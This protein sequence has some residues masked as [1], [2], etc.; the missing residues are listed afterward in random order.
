MLSEAKREPTPGTAASKG[1]KREHPSSARR[2]TRRPSPTRD[3]LGAAGSPVRKNEPLAPP[4]DA[5]S[6]LNDVPAALPKRDQ[7]RQQR[8]K[9]HWR[10][11]GDGA[12]GVLSVLEDS[13]VQPGTRRR[14]NEMVDLFGAFCRERSLA[15]GTPE[16]TDAAM[17]QFLNHRFLSGYTSS[18]GVYTVV[19]WMALNPSYGRHGPLCLLRSHRALKGWRRLEPP[20]SRIGVTIYVVSAVAAELIS[21]RR[22][23]MAV[24]TLIYHLGYLRPS[25]NMA[26]RRRCLVAPKPGACESW[27]LLLNSSEFKLMSK[28]GTTDDAVLLDLNEVPRDEARRPEREALKFTYFELVKEMS[29][30]AETI[31]T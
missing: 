11:G 28:T 12:N 3:L 10:R 30:A 22:Q 5:S 27:S 2:P 6:D 8:L 21:R 18:D 26:L 4:S 17:V 9:K 15:T 19:G 7:R 24:W 16:D 25:T 23:D 31:G 20:R 1:V 14:Y 29:A 13:A